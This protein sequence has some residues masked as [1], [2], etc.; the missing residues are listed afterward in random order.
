MSSAGLVSA[1]SQGPQWGLLFASSNLFVQNH[2][3][4]FQ[5]APG[6]GDWT[7]ETVGD[8]GPALFGLLPD[9]RP[10]PVL[11]SLQAC[12][13]QCFM[14]LEDAYTFYPALI[15][16]SEQILPS[17]CLSLSTFRTSMVKPSYPIFSSTSESLTDSL[18]A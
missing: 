12:R 4:G 18:G 15:F 8:L 13:L 10:S 1:T 3:S 16:S 6:H 17:I 7:C 11:G 5:V 9:P 2:L 14:V